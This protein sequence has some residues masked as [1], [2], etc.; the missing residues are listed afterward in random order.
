MPIYTY[1]CKDCG[2]RFDLLIGMTSEKVKLECKKCGGRNIEKTIGSFSIGGSSGDKSGF[3]G[4]SCPT[5]TCP[6]G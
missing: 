5:G 4:S 6:L 2:E 3:S 1:V